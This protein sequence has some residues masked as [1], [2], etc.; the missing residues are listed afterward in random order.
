MFKQDILRNRGNIRILIL[1]VI[2]RLSSYVY[3]LRENHYFIYCSLFIVILIY[4]FVSELIMSV[5]LRHKTN[6]GFG[7]KIEHGYGLVI[8]DRTVI[9]NNVTLRQNTTIGCKTLPDGKQGAS[10]NIGNNVDIGANVVIVGG[11]KIGDGAVIGAGSVVTKDVPEH[12]VVAG[13][14]AALLKNI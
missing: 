11:V 14:P 6:V 12:T 3:K 7:L 2:F 8:N 4:R 10:P 1:I 13:N 9:G 5:E